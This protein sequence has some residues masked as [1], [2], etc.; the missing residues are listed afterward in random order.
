[1]I[2]SGEQL[3]S[4][5]EIINIIFN[6]IQIIL[7][8]FV[9]GQFAHFIFPDFAKK[10]TRKLNF[11]NNILV[12]SI[13]LFSFS[14]AATNN[15]LRAELPNIIVPIAYVAVS[16]IFLTFLSFIWG[17]LLKFSHEDIMSII[18]TAPQKTIAM[19]IPLLSTYFADNPKLLSVSVLPIIFYHPWQ[20]FI[21]GLIKNYL[22]LQREKQSA[23][24]R[25]GGT[26]LHHDHGL[27]L[28]SGRNRP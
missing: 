1:M 19:G 7:L 2:K 22:F 17:R 27:L 3:L 21:A 11:I 25:G 26:A 10:H 4:S 24:L 13:I 12:L 15:T 6:L 14:T 28:K 16:C 9:I 8:P 18:F 5:N 23:E 20:L